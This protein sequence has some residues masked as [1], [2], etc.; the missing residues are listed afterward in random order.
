TDSEA[1]FLLALSEGLDA[2]P[3]AAMERAVNRLVGL[4]RA[5]GRVP[6]LRLAAAFAD[7]KRLY[8]V[9]AASD[10]RAPTLYHRWNAALGGRAVVSEP[11]ERDEAGW[12]AVPPGHFCVFEGEHAQVFPFDWEAVP[13]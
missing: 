9:R 8:A 11:L 7:G 2:D 3:L 6:H 5:H 13:A 12:T 10:D 4:S 1:L